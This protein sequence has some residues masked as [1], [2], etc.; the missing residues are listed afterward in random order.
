MPDA[1]TTQQKP[2]PEKD[3]KF[4]D[5]FVAYIDIMGYKQIIE[6]NT[7]EDLPSIIDGILED[8]PKQIKKDLV[9]VVYSEVKTAQENMKNIMYD[10][11]SDSIIIRLPFDE[12]DNPYLSFYDLFLFVQCLFRGLFSHGLPSRGAITHGKCF[13]GKSIFIGKPLVEAHNLSESLNFSGLVIDE[14]TVKYTE[15]LIEKKDQQFVSK[16]TCTFPVAV[17]GKEEEKKLTLLRWIT[18]D[19][20]VKI[21]DIRQFVYNQFSAHKKDVPPSLFQKI[22]NTEMT[23]REFVKNHSI[24]Q[25]FP[26]KKRETPHE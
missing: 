17:K 14:K 1:F 26:P 25:Y 11:I 13:N 3:K 22:L 5:Y 21:F 2:E 4:S 24:L 9:E 8:I 10:I 16:Y 12:H 23:I 19:D 6:N 15:A 18:R 7:V 20:F